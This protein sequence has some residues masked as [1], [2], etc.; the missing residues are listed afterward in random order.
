ML[1]VVV[2][3]W[4]NGIILM[5]VYRRTEKEDNFYYWSYINMQ[6]NLKLNLSKTVYP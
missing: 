4:E 1:C 2:Y 3:H 5:C 6:S